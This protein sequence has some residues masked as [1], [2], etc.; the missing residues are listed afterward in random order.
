MAPAEDNDSGMESQEGST[1]EEF[2]PERKAE[3]EDG[4]DE[5]VGEPP[6]ENPVCIT[7][8]LLLCGVRFV[9]LNLCFVVN[10]T[11]LFSRLNLSV[12]YLTSLFAARKEA[13]D[14]GPLRRRGENLNFDIT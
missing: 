3:I 4:L 14:R 7:L 1:K 12:C 8:L 6:L 5:E 9:R 10:V 11:S 2:T 13:A